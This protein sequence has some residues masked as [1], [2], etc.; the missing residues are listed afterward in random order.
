VRRNIDV[1]TLVFNNLNFGMTG[2]EHSVTTPCR[3]TTSTTPWG[4]TEIPLDIA[5][6]AAVNGATFVWRGTA[7]APDLDAQIEAAL[8]HDGFALLDIWELCV[9]YYAAFNKLTPGQL[10]LEIARLGFEEGMIQT[11]ARPSMP[12][13]PQPNQASHADQPPRLS[14]SIDLQFNSDLTEDLS[15]MIAGS[16]GGHIRTAGRLVCMAATMSNLWTTQRDDYPVTV[17][18]GHSLSEIQIAREPVAC[19]ACQDMDILFLL[20][21]RGLDKLREEI[22]VMAAAE[23]SRDRWI[24]M[25]P[26]L[27]DEV[28]GL[29]GSEPPE[30]VRIFVIDIR[31][32]KGIG[33]ASQGLAIV[34]AGLAW[35]EILSRDAL[36]AAAAALNPSYA[37]TNQEAVWKALTALDTVVLPLV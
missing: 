22:A 3:Q 26:D 6:T 14:P 36:V 16:A 15:V 18:A 30:G 28:R 20:D 29:L 10:K 5:A 33:R 32:L 13:L 7:Y 21:R 19:A 17:R 11:K 35:T 37:E 23:A 1:T 2:G 12:F 34:A 4:H 25:T 27:V 31:A 24:F 8:L 9:A